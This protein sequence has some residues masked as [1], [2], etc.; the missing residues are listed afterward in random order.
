[1][2]SC[3]AQ[4][5]IPSNT[6]LPADNITNTWYF[7]DPAASFDDVGD[8]AEVFLG[9]FY[10]GAAGVFSAHLY[11]PTSVEVRLYD[12][13]DPLPRP[14]R[15]TTPLS[16]TWSD[17]DPLPRETAMCLSYTTS[18]TISTLPGNRG[19]I[20]LGALRASILNADGFI[21]S[22]DIGSVT[23]ALSTA[24][25]TLGDVIWLV[26]L[27]GGLAPITRAWVDNDFDVMRKR[28]VPATSRANVTV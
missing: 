15:R 16:L 13:T 11:D 6:G 7:G 2:G 17:V 26:N 8:A 27:A 20:Y 19:R 22:A 21:E 4:L 12:P 14:L 10:N 5:V 3:I 23:T 24:L 28:Q 1:M 18:T 9:S 25:G